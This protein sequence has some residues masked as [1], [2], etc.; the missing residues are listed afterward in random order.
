M[1]EGEEAASE[2]SVRKRKR[3]RAKNPRAIRKS[4]AINQLRC[5]IGSS[6]SERFLDS[7]YTIRVDPADCCEEEEEEGFLRDR[8]CCCEPEEATV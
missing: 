2:S 6:D 3:A 7:L 5:Q 1:E 4:N 8:P